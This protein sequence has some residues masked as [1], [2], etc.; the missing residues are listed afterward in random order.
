[1]TES[2]PIEQ[3]EHAP[4]AELPEHTPI[5]QTPLARLLAGRLVLVPRGG[6][7]GEQTARQ[8]AA[9]EA[10]AVLVPLIEQVPPLDSAPF[11]AAVAA[12]N[13]GAYDWV[14]VTSAHGAAALIAAGA[15]P[16]SARVAAVGP[17]TAE[18]L[19]AAGFAVDLVPPEFT[20]AELAAHLVEV[21]R[22]GGAASDPVGAGST[23]PPSTPLSDQPAA[24]PSES[25]RV[26]LPL[27]EIAEPTLEHGLREAGLAPERVTAYRTLPVAP[28][29]AADAELL[30]LLG[31]ALV[32][33]SSGAR[34]LAERFAP[35]PDRIVVAAIG[36]PT[37]RELARLRIPA[38]VVATEH[39]AAG[40]VAALAAYAEH[41]QRAAAATSEP[42]P[43][44]LTTDSEGTA[45]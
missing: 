19:T 16:G 24:H 40:T 37:A 20:G 36:E 33:S 9:L 31:A 6:E 5:V 35:L 42:A 44:L 30:P 45:Q 32:F 3:T 27:S 21:I 7:R 8:L 15:R 28:D 34:A 12:L 29:A 23:A 41:A 39:T 38:T 10:G 13:S 11:A 2:A 17:A 14:A 22:T 43:N 4:P 1:M 26:L 18:R 25:H